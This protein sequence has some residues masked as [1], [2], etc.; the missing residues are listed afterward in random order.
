MRLRDVHGPVAA[1]SFAG[2]LGGGQS[3]TPL[4]T[5]A[6]AAAIAPARGRRRAR[7]RGRAL[8]RGRRSWPAIGAGLLVGGVLGAIPGGPGALRDEPRA[9][10]RASP[11][12][13]LAGVVGVAVAAVVAAAGQRLLIGKM[14][15]QK[16]ATIAAAGMVAIARASRPP[17]LAL[18]ALPLAAPRWRAPLPRPRRDAARPG[19]C[20]SRSRGAGVLALVARAVARRLARARPRAARRARP[21]RSC[22][23]RRTASS[24]SGPAPGARA[25]ARA[26]RRPRARAVGRA[27]SRRSSALVVGRA[28][29]RGRARL[30]RRRRRRAGAA[31][32]ARARAR[33]LTD[34]DGD[35]FSARFGGGD[36]DDT[37]ADVYPGAED[38][39]G[40]GV[41]QNCEGGDAKAVAAAPADEAPGAA[42]R[43]AAGAPPRPRRAPTPSKGNILIVTIDA[44][45]ADRLGVAGYGRPA[46]QVAD[47]DARRAGARAAPTSS[48]S[49]R[50]RPTRRARSRRSSPAATRRTSP[51]TSRA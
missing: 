10:P 39:P 48:A 21:S 15:S 20:C 51:G 12:G 5:L 50:R 45:R 42:D 41:D 35:G 23:A 30:Q 27:A 26:C 18:A 4:V 47:A 34:R 3:S 31:R 24:G 25:A 32:R 38:V 37:R 2:V 33:A 44:F 19:S 13:I 7:A 29:A 46:G 9:R 8:R 36:C 17:S 6:R 1:S 14:Q 28:P 43:R 49:G 16:L 11:T 40:D 22:S